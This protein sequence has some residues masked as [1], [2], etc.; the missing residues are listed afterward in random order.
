MYFNQSKDPALFELMGDA[1]TERLLSGFF[2]GNYGYKSKY[3]LTVTMRADGSSKFNKDNRW[4][5]FPSF[6]AGWNVKE[7]TFMQNISA[8]SRFKVRAGWGQVGNANAVG[9]WNYLSLMKLGYTN[10]FG[11]AP[12]EGAKAAIL[13]NKDLKWEVS[14]QL[15]IGRITSYNVC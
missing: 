5:Y 11:G 2:R 15:N 3:L 6:S 1:S 7:E 8:L 9:P 12:V 13:S 4:G 10:S 14:E